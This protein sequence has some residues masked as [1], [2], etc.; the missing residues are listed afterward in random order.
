MHENK[1][2]TQFTD[3]RLELGNVRCARVDSAER[4]LDDDRA[5]LRYSD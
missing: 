2:A 3:S 4:R 1:R 5:W